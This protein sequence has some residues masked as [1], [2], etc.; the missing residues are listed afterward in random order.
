MKRVQAD[1]EAQLKAALDVREMKI[2]AEMLKHFEYTGS[3]VVMITPA[4][5]IQTV[6]Q[7]Y[8][9]L[10]HYINTDAELIRVYQLLGDIQKGLLNRLNEAEKLENAEERRKLIED[11]KRNAKLSG[12]ELAK[13]MSKAFSENETAEAN[14][15]RNTAA[16]RIRQIAK[17]HKLEA[18]A[19]VYRR[20]QTRRSPRRPRNRSSPINKRKTVE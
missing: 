14:L 16:R 9:E 12:D 15:V 7:Q 3:G 20:T 19:G 11:V 10:N 18:V 1:L 13:K 17:D 6:E 4:V 2:V 5:P 8:D